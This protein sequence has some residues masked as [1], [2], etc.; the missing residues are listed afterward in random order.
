VFD[1][2]S[3]NVMVD[4]IPVNLG[5]WDTAG[6][7]DYDRLRPL[8]YPQT[9]VFL[10]AF[11]VVSPTSFLNL[12][13]KWLPEISHH[14]PEARVVLVGCKAKKEMF[15]FLVILA[16]CKFHGQS[17]LRAGNPNKQVSQ[18]DA[19]K[20]VKDN[21]LH[22]YVECSSLTQEGLKDVFDTVLRSVLGGA[23]GGAGSKKKG[24]GGGGVF[25][26]FF[27]SGSSTTVEADPEPQAPVMPKGIPAP[28]IYPSESMI[29]KDFL[30]LLEEQDPK[31]ADVE[32]HVIVLFSVFFFNV[33]C[34]CGAN[35]LLAH[36]LILSASCPLLE[37]LL[38]GKRAPAAPFVSVKKSDDNPKVT[39]IVCTE[40]VSMIVM[41]R[42]INF[43]YSGECK[44]ANK[45]DQIAETMEMAE[46]LELEFLHNYC[47]NILEDTSQG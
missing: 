10:L 42:V 11:S 2:Y 33:L 47:K 25:S 39:S 28:W 43:M 24:G 46:Q 41:T 16:F 9:D 22:A 36:S 20:V 8:S 15:F 14:C 5:L 3:A 12:S 27:K 18:E 35:S 23:K 4:G 40:S 29:A 17:D 34:K 32:I 44:I 6:Q 45:N 37:A 13:S 31:M 1:N 7:E 38:E 19:R 26:N 21:G 30:K